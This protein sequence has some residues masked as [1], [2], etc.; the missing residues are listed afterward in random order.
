[1][2]ARILC[3]DDEPRVLDGLRLNL[4]MDYEVETAER[5]VDA[6]ELMAAAEF[7]VVVSDMRMPGMDGAQLLKEVFA[8]SPDTVRL[9]LTGQSDA[10]AAARAVNEGRIFRYLSKPCSA[11]HLIDVIEEGLE[12]RRA[13][14]LEQ[15]L[16]STTLKAS[17]EVMTEVLAIAAPTSAERSRQTA[18]LAARL[19]PAMGVPAS[20][21][22]ELEVAAH[23][24]GLGAIAV[25]AELLQRAAAGQTLSPQER[26]LLDQ[27]PETSADMVDRVP[28]LDGAAALIRQASAS[29][30]R[31]EQAPA[32]AAL[33]L[34]MWVGAESGCGR[35]WPEITNVVR[36]ALNTEVARAL[37]AP[38]GRGE[39]PVRAIHAK[40]LEVGMVTCE[41]VHSSKGQ[42]IVKAETELSRP[43]VVRLQNFAK[44]VGLVEPF[45]VA[46]P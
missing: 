9:L 23:L 2:S 38:V 4:E 13:R 15:E 12:V 21:Q 7:D 6:L 31:S 26:S 19:G 30:P 27:I 37:G 16:L 29:L 40:D 11:D 17:I 1:M 8:R 41:D 39:R 43:F 18:M 44:N 45:R 24:A 14:R 10:D 35:P 33:D 3:V 42:L 25:P 32:A 22:W 5:G 34:A 36:L 28:R 46:L 20:A